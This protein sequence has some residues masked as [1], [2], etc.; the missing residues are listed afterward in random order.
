MRTISEGRAVFDRQLIFEIIEAF[1]HVP[2]VPGST[3]VMKAINANQKFQLKKAMEAMASK[4]SGDSYSEVRLS[5]SLR[6]FVKK[7]SYDKG[8]IEN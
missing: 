8:E 1:Q 3:L 6:H 2:A 5:C 4:K 7:Y